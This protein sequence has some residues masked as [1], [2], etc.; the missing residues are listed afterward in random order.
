MNEHH[1]QDDQ[2]DNQHDQHDDDLRALLAA[3]DPAASLP[4]A[5]PSRVARLLEDTMTDVHT[6]ESRTDGTRRRSRLTW[7][8]A[9]AAVVLI[10]GGILWATVGND[11]ETPP[12]AGE[13]AASPPTSEAAQSVTRLGVDTA[14]A[15]GRCLPP[16]ESPQVVAAQ[17]LAFEGTVTAISGDKVTLE[18]TRYYTGEETDLVTVTA[19]SDDMAALLAGVTFEEGGRYLVSATDARVTLCGFTAPYSEGLAAVYAEAFPG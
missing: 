4:P 13:P 7:L 8:V 19:P 11:E 14:G 2:H 6:D 5:D 3:H 18:P 10:G 17:S 16:A 15:S 12:V 9:A 1:Q